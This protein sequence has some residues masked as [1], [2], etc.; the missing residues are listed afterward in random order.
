MITIKKKESYT[1]Y[2][3]LKY[4]DT[5]EPVDLTNVE[6]FCQM[7]DVP[8]GTLLAT[9]TCTV[10]AETGEIWARFLENDTENL[11]VGECG[12]D[13]WIVESGGKHPIYTTRCHII[14]AYTEEFGGV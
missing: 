14:D 13:I 6:A 12:Y 2:L 3:Q 5:Q 9:A 1:K 4:A 10:S 11:P 7:R 8:G